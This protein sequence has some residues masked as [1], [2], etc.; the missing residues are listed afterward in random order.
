MPA[1][2]PQ[3][4]RDSPLFP[5]GGVS[6]VFKRYL[7][8]G[9]IVIVALFVLSLLIV[10]L[11]HPDHKITKVGV[12]ENVSTA[13]NPYFFQTVYTLTF[14][15]GATIRVAADRSVPIPVGKPVAIEY[16]AREGKLLGIH[17]LQDIP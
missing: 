15:D 9:I 2:P 10:P 4:I 8:R 12:I 6:L 13:G 14:R 3:L 16:S 17:L 11:L 5:I 7:L 1:I